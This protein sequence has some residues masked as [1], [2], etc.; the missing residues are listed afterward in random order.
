M[1]QAGDLHTGT[2]GWVFAKD[3]GV[4]LIHSSEVV[5]ITQIHRGLDQTGLLAI[6]GSQYFQDIL[7]HLPGLVLDTAIA[8]LSSGWIDGQLAGDE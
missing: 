4:D 1:G 8:E 6:C 5:Q 3:C 2:S 7:E